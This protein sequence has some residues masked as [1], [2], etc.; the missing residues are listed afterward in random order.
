MKQNSTF[1]HFFPSLSCLAIASIL[2]GYVPAHAEL[3]LPSSRVTSSLKV[4]SA[5]TSASTVVGKLLPGDAVVLVDSTTYWYQITLP[6]GTTGYVSR[7]WATI[8][9]DLRLGTWNVKKLGHGTSKSY[10]TIAAVINE[11]FDILTLIEVMQKGLGH[12]GYDALLQELGGS[13]S[14]V[15]S[16]TPR[17]GT[18]AGDAEF[19]AILYRPVA[20]R[21]CADGPTLQYFPDN[22]GSSQGTG[23]DLFV[24]E[25]AFACFETI[26]TTGTKG[27]DFILAAYHATW[28]DG[29]EDIIVEEADQLSQV[30]A[31]MKHARPNEADL[32]VAGD[33][34]L[35]PE[36]LK[37]H[38][39][40]ADKTTGTG[41]TLNS[42][43]ART[44]NL[45]DHLLVSDSQATSELIVP[46]QVLDVRKKASTNKMFYKTVSDHLPIVGRFFRNR[47]DDD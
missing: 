41:S 6:D 45:Y 35:T 16:E 19:Y 20:V 10:S 13:W 3:V 5:S 27:W 21:P 30:F 39:T 44:A 22:D 18:A 33:F 17:P 34:N 40:A 31:A 8:E 36:V 23:P 28:A 11:N 32:F 38:S 7:A 25:P 2:F 9:A 29:D 12:P 14:G 24:R 46:A 4:R 15:I 26:S 1:R 42:S 47:S 43:G 37:E